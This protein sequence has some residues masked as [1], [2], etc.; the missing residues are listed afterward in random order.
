MYLKSIKPNMIPPKLK[1]HLYYFPS[2]LKI[3]IYSVKYL[4]LLVVHYKVS[5]DKIFYKDTTYANL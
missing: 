3:N 1:E 2:F 5:A 4:V